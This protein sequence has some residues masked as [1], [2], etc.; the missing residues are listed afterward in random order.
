MLQRVQNHLAVPS[1]RYEKKQVKHNMATG[2]KKTSNAEGGNENGERSARFDPI[3]M[4]INH[5]QDFK[6]VEGQQTHLG[7]R[8]AFSEALLGITGQMLMCAVEKWKIFLF[9]RGTFCLGYVV[10]VFACLH[11]GYVCSSM[12]N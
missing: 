7:I 9:C 3:A 8:A 11:A 6:H 1:N 5:Q 10:F 12:S 2:E 4:P